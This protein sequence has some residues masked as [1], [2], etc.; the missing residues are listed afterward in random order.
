MALSFTA[1]GQSS[2]TPG[3]YRAR[4]VSIE[5]KFKLREKVVT[6]PASGEKA[7]KK[8]DDPYLRWVF[9]LLEPGFEGK[10]LSAL[11]GSSFGFQLSGEPAKARRYAQ[12][13]LRRELE[14]GERFTDEDLYGRELTIH[15]ELD[16]TERGVF[17]RVVE[18]L[19]LENSTEKPASK[20]P[21]T[22]KATPKA[23]F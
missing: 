7:V 23:P 15:V 22:K 17:A 9:E 10:S 3:A 21:A 8:V 16:K 2:F 12:A 5:K 14:D 4:L 6:D 19:A 13:A 1:T 11:S 20:K 18:V